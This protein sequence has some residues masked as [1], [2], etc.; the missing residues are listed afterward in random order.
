MADKCA[1]FQAIYRA[2]DNG[3]IKLGQ[4]EGKTIVI[5]FGPYWP[6]LVLKAIAHKENGNCYN[7]WC[8]GHAPMDSA[9]R[10]LQSLKSL[11]QSCR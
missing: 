5:D 7:F 1:K 2:I 8:K 9:L 11:Y 4:R 3:Q 6:R 10:R